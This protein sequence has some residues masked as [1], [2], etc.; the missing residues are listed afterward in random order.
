[1][2]AAVW[3]KPLG[4]ALQLHQVAKE[5]DIV[6]LSFE[7]AVIRHDYEHFVYIFYICGICLFLQ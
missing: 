2:S 7:L 3:T 5:S 1:M 6:A 4:S